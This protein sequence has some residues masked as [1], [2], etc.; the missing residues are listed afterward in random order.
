MTKE[1]I[2][3]TKTMLEVVN[4]YGL[5]VN[6]SGFIRC[7]FHTGDNHASLKIYRKSFYCFGCGKGGDVFT[8]VQLYENCDFHTAFIRLGGTDR[9]KGERLTDGEKIAAYRARRAVED[10]KKQEQKKKDDLK[11]IGSEIDFWRDKMN[12]SEPLS[13]EWTEAYNQWMIACQKQAEL[14]G[15]D[16]TQL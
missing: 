10:R 6:R 15:D 16:L 13:D 3:E 1:E 9:K 8:F 5:Q 11:K 2:L 14:V 7:P 12:K 4:S